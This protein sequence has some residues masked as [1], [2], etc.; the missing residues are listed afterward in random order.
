MPEPLRLALLWHMHQPNYRDAATGEVSLPW[1][2]LHATKDY[3]DMAAILRRY[4]RVHVTF[5][6]TPVLLDQ[7]EALAGGATDSYLE[8]ARRAA[9]QLTAEERRFL[10]SH[11]FD[12]NHERMLEP[13]PPYR[14]LLR[15]ARSSGENPAGGG[16][17]T[18]RGGEWPARDLR[19]LQT[20]FHLAWVD[21]GYWGEEPMRSLLAK[22][23]GFTEGEKHALLDWGLSCARAVAGEYRSLAAAGQIELCTSAYHHPILPLLVDSDAPREASATID[24]PSPPFRYPED[25]AAQIARARAAHE[26]RFGAAPRG[27]WPP[28]GAVSD[29][30]L[31]LLAQAGFR[32]TASD[33]TV[34][35][36]ALGKRDDRV[37]WPGA[38]YQAYEV[39]TPN[40]AIAM[41]FRDRT[42]SDLIGFTYARW[43]PAEAA[44]DFVRRLR[45]VRGNA[46]SA[47]AL[48]AVI[49]DGENCWESYAGDGNAFLSSLY[50]LLSE[51]PEIEAVTV[52][53]ALARVPPTERL[54]HVPV[55]SWIRPDLGI[56]VGHEE[57][58]RAW[59]E[60]GRARHALDLA[61]ESGAEGRALAESALDHMHAAEASDWFWWYGDDHATAY[62]AE[63]DRLFRAHVARVYECLR[64]PVPDSL[65]RSIRA[66]G[67]GEAAGRPDAG[68]GPMTLPS[69]QPTLDGSEA[70]SAEWRGAFE[71]RAAG[72]AGSMHHAG[73][74]MRSIRLG[75]GAQD[76]YVRIDLA[77]AASAM[78][79][80]HLV[81][82]FQGSGRRA[83]IPLGAAG[84]GVVAWEGGPPKGSE[85]GEYAVG[86]VVEARLPFRLL[87][88][89]P[90]G[91]LGLRVTFERGAGIEESAPR[92][93]WF[94][95][96][97]SGPGD[98]P[99]PGA[100][101]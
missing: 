101:P 99:A 66:G 20:W 57:K 54:R 34:L 73:A 27:T 85:A 68:S 81:F 92:S 100:A 8:V 29:R 96:A 26:R 89:Q 43:E 4:P 61:R 47:G 95:F 17:E 9:E 2:R 67:A 65:R 35:Q 10:L 88:R 74:R 71:Y 33:E 49:L 51:D 44:E 83:R 94:E 30:A 38:L 32:W 16:D 72:A 87:G 31:A 70:D 58:N 75:G 5:N 84:R 86:E 79:G 23:K 77:E 91:R 93:G 69:V 56:W 40:G 80:A 1:A 28:E 19:D 13:H 97:V 45:A 62:S 50:G 63:F 98:P 46:G 15:R 6:L 90:E 42:L 39:E 22:G 14:D 78:R 25:A 55:G 7:L 37:E 59:V 76:L 12:V 21:P 18:D 52:S 48:V 41:V 11:F 36:A 3:R 60:L 53:E 24:L 82:T 64:A